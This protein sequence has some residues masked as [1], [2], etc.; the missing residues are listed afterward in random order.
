[1]VGIFSCYAFILITQYYTDYQYEPV[2]SIA[3]AS[4]T[5]HG[6][7]VIAGLA[8]GLESTGMPV[9]VISAAI[10]A[11]YYL[12][13]NSG[14]M[15][16]GQPTGGLFGTAVAT[17]G[18]L[19]TAVYVLAMDVFGP[20]ADNAGGIVEMDPGA[21]HTV[22]QTTDR[23][24]AVGNTTKAVTKVRHFPLLFTVEQLNIFL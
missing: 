23:L 10:L 13:Q 3:K 1:M 19:S 22:R 7:N 12:G 17:M 8:V 4:T 16:A 24:D 9:M 18:M 2:R 6:T 5:G 21:A 20:I 15:A 11:S 14:L